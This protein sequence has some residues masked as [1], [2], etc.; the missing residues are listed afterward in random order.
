MHVRWYSHC[1]DGGGRSFFSMRYYLQHVIHYLSWY[2]ALFEWVLACFKLS[3]CSRF[4]T[5]CTVCIVPFVCTVWSLWCGNVV[6]IGSETFLSSIHSHAVLSLNP[7]PVLLCSG[8]F[9]SDFCVWYTA[10]WCVQTRC[11]ISVCHHRAWEEQTD[12]EQKSTQIEC[13]K[14]REK[15]SCV[16]WL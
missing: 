14:K 9:G 13:Q 12:V 7:L 2:T 15:Y 6:S 5:H 11:W 16:V 8:D 10:W 1:F 4:L 3:I